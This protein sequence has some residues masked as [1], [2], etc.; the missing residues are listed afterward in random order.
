MNDGGGAKKEREKVEQRRVNGLYI[1][2]F[3]EKMVKK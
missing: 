1:D 3:L 2:Y